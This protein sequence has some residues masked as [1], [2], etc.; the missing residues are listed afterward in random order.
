MG[1]K[2]N[3]LGNSYFAAF[4]MVVILPVHFISSRLSMR[5][6]MSKQR[7]LF[8]FFIEVNICIRIC[9]FMER[10]IF[11][12]NFEW[13]KVTNLRFIHSKLILYQNIIGKQCRRELI[14]ILTWVFL[15]NTT[16]LLHLDFH[17]LIAVIIKATIY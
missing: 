8:C 15:G 5:I 11:I 13:W 3:K 14:M 7:F 6:V 4:Y 12:R 16:F 2:T 17:L 1:Y 9:T 10:R